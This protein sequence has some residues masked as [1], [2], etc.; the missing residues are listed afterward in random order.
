MRHTH[1][2]RF[3]DKRGRFVHLR[4]VIGHLPNGLHRETRLPVA[5]CLAFSTLDFTSFKRNGQHTSVFRPFFFHLVNGPMTCRERTVSQT[6]AYFYWNYF[7]QWKILFHLLQYIALIQLKV[8][9]SKRK[10]NYYSWK[11]TLVT[12]HTEATTNIGD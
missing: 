9:I 5:L 10:F 7:F 12:L 6:K 3:I 8:K 1:R 4:R 2:W 11:Y